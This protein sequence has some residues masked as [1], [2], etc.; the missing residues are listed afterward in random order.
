MSVPSSVMLLLLNESGDM[1]EHLH[2]LKVS[3]HDQ[4]HRPPGAPRGGPQ[5]PVVPS[6]D[7]G[8]GCP[9]PADH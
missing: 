2:T 7:E 9:P 3:F 5:A 4:H 6:E 8:D 1:E